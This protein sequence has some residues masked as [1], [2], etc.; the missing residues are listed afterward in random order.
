MLLEIAV[1]DAYGSCYE[2]CDKWIIRNKN[3]L[4]YI[5][6]E[7]NPSLI[8]PG[9]YT[10]DTQMT[11][12]VAEFM[13]EDKKWDH[14][15]LAEKF[16][17]CFH[18][19]PR[20]GYAPGFYLFLLDHKNG[21]DFVRD[22]K[23]NSNRSGAAMRAAPLGLIENIDELKAKSAIQSTLTHNTQEGR[24]SAL[25]AALMTHYFRFNLGGKK[26]LPGWLNQFVN[27]N[28]GILE[29]H[30]THIPV[31]GWP[32][33][34]AALDAILRS[35]SLSEVLV[36][37]V[38]FAGDTDTICAIAM[39]PASFCKEIKQDLPQNLVDGLEN[40]EYGRDYI[41]ELDKKLMVAYD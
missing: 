37:S 27:I 22:I 10:D 14:Y 11:L 33:V 9:N 41:I 34:I 6:L 12:G 31:E 4:H 20:R 3:K 5:T 26:D 19:D 13:L 36:N 21:A 35:D 7:E 29:K 30:K 25:C 15:G 8:K 32:C 16:T 1:G 2:W 38:N 28:L 24:D 18:R 40:G 23:G 17:E 39:G